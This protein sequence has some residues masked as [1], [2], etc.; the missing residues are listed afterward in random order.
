MQ[1]V[2]GGIT[3]LRTLRAEFTPGGDENAA[4]RAAMLARRFTVTVLPDTEAAAQTL[5]D[6]LPALIALARL[7]DVQLS[8]AP[9]ELGA[10]DTKYVATS[11]PGATFYLPASELLEGID[12]QRETARLTQEIAKLDKELVGVQGRLNNPNF[13][14]RAL[15]E[16]VEKTQQDALDLAQRREKLE[17]RRALLA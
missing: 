1:L 15:P 13:M 11:V 8:P 6:Q 14:A 10:G 4:A 2:I 12:P 3:A 17:A 9:P 16:V 7:G 5:R